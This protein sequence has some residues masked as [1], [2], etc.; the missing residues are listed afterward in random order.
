[1]P[2]TEPRPVNAG[3][4]RVAAILLLMLTSIGVAADKTDIEIT[5][6][7]PRCQF[8][9]MGAVE[10]KDGR[11]MGEAVGTSKRANL[12]RAE[13]R[14]IRQAEKRGASRIVLTQRNIQKDGER[15]RYIH[16]I[17]IAIGP[18]MES[19]LGN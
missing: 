9:R 13:A 4:T 7:W 14:L 5:D 11:K 3:L 10:T 16:L 12:K 8:E 2:L 19:E 6:K 1:M 15:I 18:C 17:G